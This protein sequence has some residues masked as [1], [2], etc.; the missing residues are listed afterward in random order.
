[1]TFLFGPNYLNIFTQ[2]ILEKEEKG[3]DLFKVYLAFNPDYGHR[4]WSYKDYS[5]DKFFIKLTP[6]NYKKI[7]INPEYPVL[8][9]NN[10]FV[11]I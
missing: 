3:S 4:F 1:M 7:E 10:D 2:F 8:N 5:T 9:Y 11:L 6:E